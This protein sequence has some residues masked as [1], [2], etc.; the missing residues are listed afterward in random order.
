MIVGRKIAN[1][2]NLH[3]KDGVIPGE[4]RGQPTSERRIAFTKTPTKRLKT[5]PS[6]AQSCPTQF[7]EKPR[8]H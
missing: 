4:Y 1:Q 3:K 5:R 8:K 2:Q 6:I 7:V